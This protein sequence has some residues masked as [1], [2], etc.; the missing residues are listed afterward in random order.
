MMRQLIA[1]VLLTFTSTVNSLDLGDSLPENSEYLYIKLKLGPSGFFD[2]YS[3]TE[4]GI[5][6]SISIDENKRIN[7]LSSNSPK[8]SVFDIHIGDSI[9]AV[10]DKY[11][12]DL[13]EDRDLGFYI[14]LDSGWYAD[15]S[16]YDVKSRTVRNAGK[17]TSFFKK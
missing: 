7:Y 3:A 1:I 5:E 2:L 10:K 16:D 15:F 9:E 11:D 8:F 12:H 6:Y 17:V 4:K 14:Y 13:I